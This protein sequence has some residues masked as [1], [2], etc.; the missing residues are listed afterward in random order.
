[1]ELDQVLDNGLQGS[2]STLSDTKE[3]LAK[4]PIGKNF[5]DLIPRVRFP[6]GGSVLQVRK[7]R[8]VS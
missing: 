1:M 8:T 2:I 6:A 4:L 3:T 5:I 7:G